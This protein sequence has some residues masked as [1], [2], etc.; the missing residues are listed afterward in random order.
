M[1]WR[2]KTDSMLTQALQAEKTRARTIVGIV[3]AAGRGSRFDNTGTRN[4][5]LSLIDGVPTLGL[6]VSSMTTVLSQVVVVVKPG[7]QSQNLSAVARSFGATS[8]ECP[9]AASGMG[10]SLAWAIAHTQSHF[11]AFGVVIGLGDMPFVSSL[12]VQSVAAHLR[13][14][15][16]IVVPRYDGKT[17]NPIGFGSAHFEQLGRLNGDRGARSLVL[18][19]ATQIINV[20]DPGILEDIDTLDD[21]ARVN[22]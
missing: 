19:K 21:L 10:H 1:F 7:D 15:N 11:D 8:I 12:T 16:D 18:Q 5:L 17:G 13:N 20:N 3:L 14:E 6:S 22:L 4:K 9:D 2:R